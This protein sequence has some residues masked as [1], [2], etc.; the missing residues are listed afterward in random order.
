VKKTWDTQNIDLL[1]SIFHPDMVWPWPKSP[2]SPDPMDWILKWG[3][4]DYNRGRN[5]WLK[6]LISINCNIITGK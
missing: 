1:M 2:Q 3:R 5:G 4:Y 6:L